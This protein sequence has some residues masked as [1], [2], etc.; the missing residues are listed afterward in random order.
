MS[1]YLTKAFEFQREGQLMKAGLELAKLMDKERESLLEEFVPDHWEPIISVGFLS[2][3]NS[4]G[5]RYDE[6]YQSLKKKILSRLLK[7]WDAEKIDAA[8]RGL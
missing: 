3:A 8:M 2:Y 4:C 5:F 7:V 6:R 1:P